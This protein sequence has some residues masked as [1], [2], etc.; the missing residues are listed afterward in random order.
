MKA[1]PAAPRLVSLTLNA[2]VFLSANDLQ[3]LDSLVLHL[4]TGGGRL[5]LRLFGPPQV[6]ERP[7][8]VQASSGPQLSGAVRVAGALVLTLPVIPDPPPEVTL[9]GLTGMTGMLARLEAVHDP[10]LRSQILQTD[11]LRAAPARSDTEPGDAL[12]MFLDKNNG[13]YAAL[14]VSD[15]ARMPAGAGHDAVIARLL[16]AI[17]ADGDTGSIALGLKLLMTSGKR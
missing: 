17:S 12:R 1:R 16:Q 13:L 4:A 5:T 3:A 15:A 10:A 6:L 7:L 2:S 9:R 8:Q 14:A 11:A